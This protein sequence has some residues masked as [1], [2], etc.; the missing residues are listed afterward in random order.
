MS[1]TQ[2]GPGNIV[3]NGLV[4]YLDAA[5]PN[6]YVSGSTT[7][8]DISSGGNNGTLING[9]TYSSANGGSI[10]FDGLDDYVN[11]GVNLDNIFTGSSFTV[12]MWVS[13]SINLPDGNGYSLISNYSGDIPINAGFQ[14]GWRGGLGDTLYA[15]GDGYLSRTLNNVTGLTSNVWY[16]ITFVYV[17]NTSG[18]IYLDGINK[19]N[20][21]FT[22]TVNAPSQN[23]KLGVR[24]DNNTFPWYGKMAITQVYNRALSD[25]EILQNYNSARARFGI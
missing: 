4:L 15:F 2:G 19:T 6:S 9:P 20:T 3:T 13:I 18:N 25:S 11:L 22:N 21:S 24:S 16:N 14:L 5:N 7:W 23:L 12:N 1:T 8:N 10:V 17:R